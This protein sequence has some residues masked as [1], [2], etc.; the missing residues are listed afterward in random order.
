MQSVPFFGKS[1][2]S[3]VKKITKTDLFQTF[4]K[5]NCILNPLSKLSIKGTEYKS[6]SFNTVM[7]LEVLINEHKDT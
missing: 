7:H 2:F 4:E 1:L 6:Q 5:I 3:S